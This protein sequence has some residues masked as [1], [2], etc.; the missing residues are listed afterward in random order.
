MLE[1]RY[2]TTTKELTGWWASRFGNWDIKLL[3]RPD[4]AIVELDIDVPELSL[5]AY[6]YDEAT[7]SLISNPSYSPPDGDI[8]RAEELLA[9]SPQVITQPEIW[10]L[11]R[12]FGRRLGYRFDN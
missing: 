8:A 6:L 10:E 9:S 12:I 3:N 11:L 4:E 1:V 7:Q 5:Q 2:N